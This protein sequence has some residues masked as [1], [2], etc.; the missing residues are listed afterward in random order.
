MQTGSKRLTDLVNFWAI[1][2]LRS[3]A[4][5]RAELLPWMHSHREQVHH[6]GQLRFD[7]SAAF[8][9][10]HI[11]FSTAIRATFVHEFSRQNSHLCFNFIRPTPICQT[12][13]RGS[14]VSLVKCGNAYHW[15]AVL[16]L[17]IHSSTYTPACHHAMPQVFTGQWFNCTLPK[18]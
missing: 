7:H 3:A 18:I 12:H 16:V 14:H 4:C 17:L 10:I 15:L 13:I 2:Q 5:V 1:H 8:E 11:F 6:S 9:G